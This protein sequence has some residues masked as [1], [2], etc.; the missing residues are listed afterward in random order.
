MKR[1]L[2]LTALTITMLGAVAA[3]AWAFLIPHPEGDTVILRIS[4]TPNYWAESFEP[5]TLTLR[6]DGRV[7]IRESGPTPEVHRFRITEEGVQIVLRGARDARL[8]DDST[9]YG[10]APITDQGTTSVR[11][12]AAGEHT[13]ADVYA[14]DITAG[15]DGVDP[16]LLPARRALRNFVDDVLNPDFYGDVRRS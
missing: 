3:P 12:R 2:L 13:K 14:L 5:G 6:G 16:A 7:V 11:L 9:D 4:V 8:F 1:L 15:D 10:E